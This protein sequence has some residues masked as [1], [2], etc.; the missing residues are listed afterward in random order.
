MK[1]TFTLTG[2]CLFYIAYAQKSNRLPLLGSL[3][4]ASSVQ[5]TSCTRR[6]IWHS[7]RLLLAKWFHRSQFLYLLMGSIWMS[8]FS[9]M[10]HYY[11][12]NWYLQNTGKVDGD[13]PWR[14]TGTSSWFPLPS[15]T[16]KAP[17]HANARFW[18]M[19]LWALRAPFSDDLKSMDTVRPTMCL[20]RLTA[21][22][23]PSFNRLPWPSS[24]QSMSH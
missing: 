17:M 8:L 21:A 3:E 12:S 14:F 13:L 23:R 7:C 19:G 2:S 15:T 18:Q 1:Y 6:N 24:K 10:L 16:W 11:D 20:K 4:F 22:L 9:K 5:D